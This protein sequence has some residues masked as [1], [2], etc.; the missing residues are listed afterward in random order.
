MRGARRAGGGVGM[1]VVA[2]IGVISAPGAAGAWEPWIG[3]DGVAGLAPS[4]A[5]GPG[6]RAVVGVVAIGTHPSAQQVALTME[7]QQP[8]LT[9]PGDARIPLDRLEW[10]FQRH[11]TDPLTFHPMR[12]GVVAV[13]QAGGGWLGDVVWRFGPRW[14][15]AAVAGPYEVDIAYTLSPSSVDHSPALV[16][17]DPYPLGS[18]RTLDLY[19]YRDEPGHVFVQFWPGGG[20]PCSTSMAV[21]Y[22]YPYP[23]QAGWNLLRLS[24]GDPGVPVMQPGAYCYG[25]S[26]SIYGP[27][28]AGGALQVVEAGALGALQVTVSGEPDGRPLAGATVRLAAEGEAFGRTAS[29]GDDGRAG[30]GGLT[31]GAYRLEAQADGYVAATRQV[32]VTADT[33]MPTPVSMRLTQAPAATL[34]L[35]VRPAGAEPRVAVGDRLR[36]E[37]TLELHGQGVEGF[38]EVQ[39]DLG[40]ALAVVPGSWRIRPAAGGDGD[41]VT[42]RPPLLVWRRPA[43]GPGRAVLEADAVVTPLA[44][45]LRSVQVEA[46]CR[47]GSPGGE[48]RP[49]AVS[50]AVELDPE[51]REPRGLVLG[52]LQRPSVGGAEQPWWVVAEDGTW[53]EVDAAGY[54]SMALAEGVHVLRAHPG[55]ASGSEPVRAGPAVVVRVQPGAVVPVTLRG[56]PANATSSGLARAV[57]V[58]AAGRLVWAPGGPV[59]G[60]AGM[61]LR[62]RAPGLGLRAAGSAAGD[63]VTL[64]HAELRLGHHLLAAGDLDA[65]GLRRAVGDDGGRLPS[66]G[67]PPLQELSLGPL[68]SWPKHGLAWRWER[69]GLAVVASRSDETTG[70]RSQPDW[71]AVARAALEE[72]LVW[73]GARQE[74][75][76]PSLWGAGWE[77]RLGAWRLSAELV[78]GAGE[79]GWGVAAD[80]GWTSLRLR[81]LA[82][83][84]AARLSEGSRDG[85]ALPAQDRWEL[86]WRTRLD[87]ALARGWGL[88]ARLGRSS[89]LYARLEAGLPGRHAAHPASGGEGGVVA[90]LRVGGV[91]V[92]AEGPDSPAI[93]PRATPYVTAGLTLPSF[94]L[95]PLRAAAGL[96]LWALGAHLAA[97]TPWESWVALEGAWDG[98]GSAAVRAS[99]LPADDAARLSLRGELRP[100]GPL[101]LSSQA[102]AARGSLRWEEATIAWEALHGRALLRWRPGRW[103]AEAWLR[104]RPAPATDHLRLSAALRWGEEEPGETLT[105]AGAWQRG[106]VAVSG[107]VRLGDRASEARLSGWAGLGDG[108]RAGPD[109]TTGLYARLGW[110]GV[111]EPQRGARLDTM[112]ASVGARRAVAG[113]FGLFAEA[114][115]FATREVPSGGGSLPALDVATGA[116]AVAGLFLLVPGD[117][118][119]IL[120]LG[121]RAA[122]WGQA[123]QAGADLALDRRPGWVVRLSGWWT[124]PEADR[125]NIP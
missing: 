117:T 32:Q 90:S 46:A 57:E 113:P 3:A 102:A 63:G 53:A 47:I 55:A 28:I 84:M 56:D 15:D 88:G 96:D 11:P 118:G 52:T 72:G 98:G 6:E 41:A 93:R 34:S 112:Q 109:G 119:G 95:G 43:G 30:F 36:L 124:A 1:V 71:V 107:E 111:P 4:V 12:T 33:G 103:Q 51:A 27:I 116:A 120:E 24:P 22:G 82:A 73:A 7:A 100:G 70:E 67:T 106:P 21:G 99:V 39:V 122:T 62:A 92:D 105:L 61:G 48:W 31:P 13:H 83:D 104:P 89:D 79:A 115:G 68:P 9:G 38:T 40:P 108:G 14:E 16:W 49:P 23:V 29:T 76:A 44:A 75:A 18:G 66:G 35:Q 110:R 85:P 8:H 26:A 10:A 58:D 94:R 37:V 17:P 65:L 50:A 77:S 121:W 42:W 97:G 86:E 64:A 60:W 101:R 125:Y 78:Q 87:H 81:H 59:E 123:P 80:D 69:G 2:L 114:E 91:V 54:F 25:I 74:P 45:G 19:V 5:V 20:G